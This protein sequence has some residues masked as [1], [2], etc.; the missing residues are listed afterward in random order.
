MSHFKKNKGFS[1]IELIVTITILGVFS[2]IAIPSFTSL[3]NNNR[4]QSTS[5]ELASLLQYAR[6]TAAQNNATY[7][8]CISSGIWT[9]KKGNACS[10]TVDLRSYEPPTNFNI[11]YTTNMLPM[12]FYSNGTTSVASAGA[13]LIVCKGTDAANGYKLTVKNSGQ[14]RVWNKGKT[15]AGAALTSC[16]PT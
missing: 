13:G 3:V 4:L 16:T 5:N 10:S 2:A 9:V 14:I 11:A 8:T 15:E 7:I 12:T 6:S 1:L